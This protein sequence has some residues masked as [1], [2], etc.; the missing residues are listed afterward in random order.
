MSGLALYNSHAFQA[1]KKPEFR[2]FL[3]VFGFVGLLCYHA[4]KRL[5]LGSVEPSTQKP[6]YIFLM[7]LVCCYIRWGHGGFGSELV[8]S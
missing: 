1:P 8:G 2:L 6:L 4:S 7:Q 5:Y 3:H